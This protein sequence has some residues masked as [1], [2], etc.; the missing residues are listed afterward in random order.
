MFTPLTTTILILCITIVLFFSGRFPLGV[1]G[2]FCTLSLLVTG[3]LPASDAF[4]GFANTSTVIM[5]S[6][7]IVSAG[8]MKTSIL[9]RIMSL[10]KHSGGKS[11]SAII[12]SIGIVCVLLSQFMNGFVI[13]ACILPFVDGLC[14]EAG[15]RPS[16][17]LY[18]LMIVTFSWL[19]LFPLAAGLNILASMNGYL[20]TY[21]SHILFGTWD[22]AVARLPGA[23]LT[24]LYAIFILPRYCPDRDTQLSQASAKGLQNTTLSKPKEILAFVIACG[25]IALMLTT[26]IHGLPL[27]SC[28]AVGAFL[29]VV[30]G[31]L[32][33]KEC[34]AAISWNTIFMFAGIL[35]LAKAFEATGANNVISGLITG[36]LGGT[37]NPL[38]ISAV[39][40][41]VALFLTQVMS[42]A[43]VATVFRALTAMICAS[44]DMN[45]IGPMSLVYIAACCGFMTPAAAEAVPMVMGAGGYTLK[46]TLKLGLIPAL[47]MVGTSALWCSVV[48]PA[49]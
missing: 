18:P 6:M 35:P 1:C 36:L 41:F 5:V 30:T 49:Y 24:T 12:A 32:T 10:A 9:P 25:T 4:S 29:M 48:F 31:V 45:P 19:T 47:L 2:M 39:F 15:I 20:E 37:T 46:D 14:Q 40:A 3:V 44:L 21:S 23:I 13:I 43:A 27:Y 42:N 16:R 28:A 7:M 11:P 17:V 8:L 38:V 33:D 26:R 22:M 34:F